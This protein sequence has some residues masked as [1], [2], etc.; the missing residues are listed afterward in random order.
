MEVLGDDNS[1]VCGIRFVEITLGE[2]D[3][4]GNMYGVKECR[5]T[6]IVSPRQVI[7]SYGWVKPATTPSSKWLM[8]SCNIFKRLT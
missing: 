2:L 6:L 7:P 1:N 5:S 4:S 3:E 8:L